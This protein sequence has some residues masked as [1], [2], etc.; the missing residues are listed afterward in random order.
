MK[1]LKHQIETKDKPRPLAKGKSEESRSGRTEIIPEQSKK[2]VDSN[3]NLTVESG[4]L[5]V[6][7][8]DPERRSRW[9]SNF[10]QS[11]TKQCV[12]NCWHGGSRD[13][14]TFFFKQ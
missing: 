4:D 12:L 6:N 14:F 5:S 7:K 13:I 9:K 8:M 3:D 10:Q 2:L 1:A 11:Y